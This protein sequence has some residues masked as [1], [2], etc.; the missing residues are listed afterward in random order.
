[1]KVNQTLREWHFYTIFFKVL[2]YGPE[3]LAFQCSPFANRR[4]DPDNEVYR[5]FSQFIYKNRR[6]RIKEGKRLFVYEVFNQ[7]DCC[8]G[9]VTVADSKFELE[10]SGRVTYNVC[11]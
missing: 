8:V 11:N 5:T 2:L 6:I 4:P 3:K 10:P 9:I 7:K 1:M